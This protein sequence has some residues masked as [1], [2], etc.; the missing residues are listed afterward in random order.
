M[1]APTRRDAAGSPE[2]VIRLSGVTARRGDR[3]VWADG[4]F[5]VG[6][7]SVV[8]VIGP[9]GSGKSTLLA[10]ILGLLQPAA[11][12]VEVFGSVP[13]RGDPRIGYVPQGDEA[14]VAE[15]IRCRDLVGLGLF[16]DRWG[17]RRGG[18]VD[19]SRIDE[20]IDVVGAR[21]Y[22]HRRLSEVSGGQRQRVAMAQALVR[23]PELLLLDEP[24]ANLDVR[25]A[26]EIAS[27]LGRVSAERGITTLV[28]T[29]DINP[30]LSVLTSAV[31]LLDGHPHHA[32][33][34]DVV[35]EDLLSHLYGTS[36]KVVRTAQGDLF[37]RSG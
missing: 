33:I 23:S 16:G 24:L 4:S 19:R 7:G 32:P 15:A 25:N 11:G 14:R 5:E 30:L 35:E 1:T 21:S 27:V 37:T 2:P 26:H 20:A 34:G 9:N 3:T 29:H 28:V 8:G 10:L 17:W 18:A 36:V 31:Y 12:E 13:R 6:R 22:A